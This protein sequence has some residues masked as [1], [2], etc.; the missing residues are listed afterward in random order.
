M[1]DENTH[2]PRHIQSTET[3]FSILELLQEKGRCGV[4]KVANELDMAKSTAHRHLNTLVN[5][6]Y[7]LKDGDQYRLGLRFLDLGE[8][9]RNS[10]RVY[11]LARPVVDNLVEQ[12]QERAQFIVE[13]HGYGVYVYRQRG[14]HGVQTDPGIGKRFPLHV[15]SAGKAI[16]AHLPRDRVLDII[17]RRGLPAETPYTI[18]D[19]DELFDELEMIR[20]RGYSFNDQEMIEGLRSVGVPIKHPSGTVY[21]SMSVSGPIGRFKGEWYKQELPDL[22]VGMAHEV[23]LNIEYS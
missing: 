15:T 6:E 8:R 1:T 13:E 19:E 3:V 2:G 17:D 20:E 18:T 23:E 9:A 10:Y 7:V 11:E 5:L 21:G 4:S 12:T 14:E 16:L 22:L